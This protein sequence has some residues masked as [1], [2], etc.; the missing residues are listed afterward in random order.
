MFL[1]RGVVVSLFAGLALM[2]GVAAHGAETDPVVASVNGKVVRLSDVENA[3]NLLPTKLQ[4]APLREVYP[5]LMES[6]INSSLASEK[7]VKLG[8]DETPEYRLRMARISD[9]ILERILLARH[10]EQ[11]LSDDLIKQRYEQVAEKAAAQS[12][13]HARHILVTSEDHAK[14]LIGLL[15]DGDNFAQLAAEHST[16][17]SKT[18]GGDLGWFGPGQMVAEFENA[19][20]ALPTGEFTHEPVKT[21][22]GWHVILVEERRP[23]VVPSYQ[24][25]REILANELSAELGQK[26][27]EQLRSE[28]KIEKKSFEDVVK[29]LQQ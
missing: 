4:G 22:F 12:E 17:P 5:V 7:A 11:H 15:E 24:D 20:M 29:A 13:I 8:F 14:A 25:V 1:K 16:G 21:K 6:L 2:A 23:F 27:M 9:Q 26:Y 28:A 3:R 19:A 18:R 10:I